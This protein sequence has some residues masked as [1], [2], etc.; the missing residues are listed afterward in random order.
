VTDHP[1]FPAPRPRS[2]WPSGCGRDRGP[3]ARSR[4]RRRCP[5]VEARMVGLETY[6]SQRDAAQTPEPRTAPG[7]SASRSRG[8]EASGARRRRPSDVPR[9]RCP[10]PP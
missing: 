7:P 6:S 10:G 3:G 4:C 8:P 1:G 9:G 2:A 5:R